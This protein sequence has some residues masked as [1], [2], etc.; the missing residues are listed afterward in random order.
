MYYYNTKIFQYMSNR[1][2]LCQ[3]VFTFCHWSFAI[4]TQDISALK[5]RRNVLCCRESFVGRAARS[6]N[7]ISRATRDYSLLYICKYVQET[8]FW[9]WRVCRKR[10]YAAPSVH[11]AAIS[12][13][14]HDRC[15]HIE[16]RLPPKP[17]RRRQARLLGIRFRF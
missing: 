1:S 17:V 4:T 14:H 5:R 15:L 10:D 7:R 13:V 11:S 2:Q 12:E 8:I 6:C 16:E 3:E 9:F